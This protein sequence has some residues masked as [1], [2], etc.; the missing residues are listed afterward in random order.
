MARRLWVRH[1]RLK[2]GLIGRHLLLAPS[3]ALSGQL[4]GLSDT[5]LS[6]W[7]CP[8]SPRMGPTLLSRP[9][10][11][12][13]QPGN[14][15]RDPGDFSWGGRCKETSLHLHRG[16]SVSTEGQKPW[17]GRGCQV[18][19]PAPLAP[20]HGNSTLRCRCQG[21]V[22]DG[23]S[24]K[25]GI[26][27]LGRV[28]WAH[29]QPRSWQGSPQAPQLEEEGG[30]QPGGGRGQ[31][32][33]LLT[34]TFCEFSPAASRPHNPRPG[35]SWRHRGTLWVAAGTI[36]LPAAVCTWWAAAPHG[37]A[38]ACTA[39]PNGNGGSEP[40]TPRVLNGTLRWV[41]RHR[42]TQSRV[43][44]RGGSQAMAE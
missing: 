39:S 25:W 5:G 22:W 13:S 11:L 27:H 9:S 38:G 2:R 31:P 44:P 15:S 1:G 12:T 43:P 33:L 36:W 8:W 14:Q 19:I 24:T 7:P 37:H 42:S 40:S 18:P 4:G 6:L 26:W 21:P 3:W 10:R 41:G 20:G 28:T 34:Q 32:L 17:G 29:A 30:G 16:V 23:L 35:S